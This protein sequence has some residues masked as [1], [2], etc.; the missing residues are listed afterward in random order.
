[1]YK[2]FADFSINADSTYS[3]KIHQFQFRR[4]CAYCAR[5]SVFRVWNSLECNLPEFSYVRTK[6]SHVSRNIFS[7]PPPL[8]FFL[9]WTQFSRNFL[10][11]S[12]T[13]PRQLLFEANCAT[14]LIKG[15]LVE[16]RYRA[17]IEKGEIPSF[18][19]SEHKRVHAW[20]FER[21]FIRFALDQPTIHTGQSYQSNVSLAICT[22]KKTR[23]SFLHASTCPWLLQFFSNQSLSSVS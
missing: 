7:F 23:P 10:S 2:I 11:I 12:L 21:Q 14:R 6:I 9:F 17:S 22:D 20:L 15:S 4:S 13:A 8:P 5:W 19:R 3:D 1:M 18:L 16:D